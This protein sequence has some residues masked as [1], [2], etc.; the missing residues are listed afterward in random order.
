MT[1]IRINS[2]R[3]KKCY[4]CLELC[5]AKVFE[6]SEIHKKE[7]D[8][9]GVVAE[10]CKLCLQ[11][12]YWCPE[13]AISVLKEVSTEA[14]ETNVV[15]SEVTLTDKKPRGGWHSQKSHLTAGQYLIS[16]NEAFVEGAIAAGCRFFAG[17]PITPASEILEVMLKKMSRF[18]GI[19]IQMEDEIA[20]MGAVIGASW[21]GRK[22]LTATS[23]PGFSLM[24]ENISYADMT[25]TPCVIIDVQRGGP[26]TGMPTKPASGDIR[27]ARWG[28]HGG[29]PHIA[30][31]PASVQE[32]YE[33]TILAFNLAEIY[34]TP[35]VIL[36]DAYLSHL[37][38]TVII[39]SRL[40]LYERKYLPGAPPFGPTEDYSSPSMPDLT[41][42]EYLS[43]T[44]S[45]HNQ[46]G[47]RTTSDARSYQD[48]VWHLRNKIMNKP[49]VAVEEFWLDDAEIVIVAYG[50]V[51]RAAKAAIKQARKEGIKVGLLRPKI[52]WP[53]PTE[54]IQKWSR[55]NQVFLVPEMNQGQLNYVVR[56]RITNEV[57]SLPQQDG[58][59]ITPERILN[60]LRGGKW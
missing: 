20:S 28:D 34:R 18:G 3:C 11:C 19:A 35:I 45:A 13:G 58:N 31:C 15:K 36:S 43:I 59:I 30:L 33:F 44:G 29:F 40:K 5:P 25:E 16:G 1:E 48:L 57:V 8:V 52:L 26:S 6:K 56:E 23:G 14:G 9:I 32:C 22:A 7:P 55:R 39:K 21:S 41:D 53:F 2:T 54:F 38:E 60:F 12:E 27:I 10:K 4:L 49:P 24:Q 42:G 46:W 37:Y 47:V 17:Y 50:M 51:A